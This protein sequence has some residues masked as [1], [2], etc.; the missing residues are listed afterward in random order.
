M[1]VCSGLLYKKEPLKNLLIYKNLHITIVYKNFFM[2]RLWTIWAKALGSKANEKD[3][4]YSDKVAIIRT[5]I[6]FQAVITNL[7]ICLNIYKNW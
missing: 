5:V 4:W 3:N 2:E 7:L 6:V 1:R